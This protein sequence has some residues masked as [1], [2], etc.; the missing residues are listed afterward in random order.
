MLANII[1]DIVVWVS[2]VGA[3]LFPVA[4]SIF[5]KWWA[6]ENK[7]FGWHLMSF[8]LLAL[9][10]LLNSAARLLWNNYNGY[11]QVSFALGILTVGVIWWR[12]I[13]YFRTRFRNRL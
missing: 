8:S 10:T 9:A 5:N 13:L 7:E 3:V 11:R 4:Y 2:L 1:R 12:V 6:G